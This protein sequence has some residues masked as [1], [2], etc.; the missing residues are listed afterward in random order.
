MMDNLDSAFWH[1]DF[2][3]LIDRSHVPVAATVALKVL[4]DDNM[5]SVSDGHRSA[6]RPW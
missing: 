6:Y 2:G 1:E 4:R 5:E 3:F